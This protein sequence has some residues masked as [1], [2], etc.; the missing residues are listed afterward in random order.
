MVVLFHMGFMTQIPALRAMRMPLYFILSGL[1][2]KDYSSFLDFSIRKINKIII[3]F[4]FFFVLMV[5][6]QTLR[7]R[8][9]ETII[10]EI[11][12]PFSQNYISNLPIWFLLSLFEVNIIYRIIR[13][14]TK[15]TYLTA[16][17]V[18]IFGSIGFWLSHNSIYLPLFLGSACSA[19][20][21]FFIG[22]IMRKMPILYKNEKDA[23]FISMS[24]LLAVI[25]AVY[26]ILYGTPFLEFRMNSYQG[27]IIEIYLVSITLVVGLLMI[28][29]VAKWLPIISYIGRYS[30]IVLGLHWP[31]ALYIGK[32][33][34][35]CFGF[36][37]SYEAQILSTL[38]LCWLSIPI[39]KKFIPYFTAQADLI[40]LS[41]KKEQLKPAS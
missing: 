3:P 18:L 29:K 30:I 33:F 25:A 26:C 5:C 12:R 7:T 4:L 22:T 24:I 11:W 8:S 34:N 13:S 21:F 16:L 38:L 27:N 41:I 28:C 15:N 14:Y 6:L 2:Y 20:P 17:F 37:L 36:H 10:E 9:L 1:F 19:L 32:T 31:Y 40:K 23:L 39:C 35:Y